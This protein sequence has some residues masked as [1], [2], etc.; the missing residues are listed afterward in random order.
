MKRIFLY[1]APIVLLAVGCKKDY[2]ETAPSNAVS[3]DV[4][5][6]KLNTVYAALDGAVKEQFAFGIGSSTGH[7]NYGQKSFDLQNDLQGNDM[8]VHSQGYGWYNANYNL[9]EWGRPQEGRQ[10]DNA[11]YFYYDV[12]GQANRML[13]IV[14]GIAD[15]TQDQKDA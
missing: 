1:I 11:W 13:A 10:S 8:I 12:I 14:D 4:V 3:E 7:D 9:V 5:F 15:A 2:L 6:S